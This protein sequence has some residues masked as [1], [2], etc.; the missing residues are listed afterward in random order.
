MSVRRVE[1]RYKG[2]VEDRIQAAF[3]GKTWQDVNKMVVGVSSLT[4]HVRWG[5]HRSLRTVSDKH[6][7]R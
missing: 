7:S 2:I 1:W 6:I 4:T 5:C 3:A